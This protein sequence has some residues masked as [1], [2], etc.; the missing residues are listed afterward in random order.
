MKKQL[1]VIL[2]LLVIFP[3]QSQ[4]LMSLIFGDDLNSEKMAFGIHLDQAWNQY[5][6]LEEGKPLRTFNMGLF[7]T[8]KFDD[9][10]KGNLMMLAKY[11]KGISEL[12][13]Y[14]LG[15]DNLDASFSEA[16]VSREINYL[17]IP[18]TI[19]YMA[20]F[21][22]FLEA[23]PQLSFRTRARDIFTVSDGKDQLVYINRIDEE[24]TRWD[25][26]FVVGTGIYLGPEKLTA[27]GFR[28]HGGFTD[29]LKNESGN[30]VN[31]QWSI[32]VQIPIGRGKMKPESQ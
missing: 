28:Y 19:Q 22:G 10:W 31:M 17:S 32:F 5:S 11:K 8:R 6:G 12:S 24:V 23:G 16:Q 3:V 25:F 13:A 2:F 7:F 29:I 30:Q 9:H 4:I 26:G 20:D 27:V 1:S 14:G 15:D 18:V 21:G